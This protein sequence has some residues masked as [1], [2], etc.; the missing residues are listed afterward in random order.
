MLIGTGY[1]NA[2]V[3]DITEQYF[4]GFTQDLMGVHTVFKVEVILNKP[5]MTTTG[6]ETN[7]M[8]LYETRGIKTLRLTDVMPRIY[9]N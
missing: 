7:K 9:H 4:I 6:K 2:T 8:T 5:I 3:I 1:K